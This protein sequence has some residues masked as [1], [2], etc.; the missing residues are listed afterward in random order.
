ME[1]AREIGIDIPEVRLVPLNQIEGLPED[2]ARFEGNALAV[3]RF[4][5]SE[6]GR[7]VIWK[8]WLR[9][10]DCIRRKNTSVQAI[11]ILPTS[12]GPKPANRE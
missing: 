7:L 11:K 10:L 1:L 12:F 2:L 5:R 4:D 9:F 6:D 3:R 8:I